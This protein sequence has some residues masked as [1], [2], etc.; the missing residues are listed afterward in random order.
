M[1][2]S[3][4]LPADAG[5]SAAPADD[6]TYL[7]RIDPLGGRW[8][9]ERIGEKDF[10][11]LDAQIDFSAGGFLNH[12]AGCGGGHPAFYRLNGGQITITRIERV[13]IGKCPG[14]TAAERT[15]AG[16]SEQVLAS[17]IDRLATW[18]REGDVLTLTARD[19][20][21]AVLRKPVDPNPEL[22]G[23]WLIESIGGRPL[24]TERRPATLSIGA[25]S[26]GAHADCNRMGTQFAIPSP[27]RMLVKG[28][29]MSTQIGCA[30]EDRAEDALMAGAITGAT[31]YRLDGDR[32]IFTGG[33]GMVVRRPPPPDRRLTGEYEAC[34]NTMLGAYHEGPITLAVSGNEMRD[35]AEC[36]AKYAAN[37]PD[38]ELRLAGSP[39]CAAVAPPYAAGQPVGVGGAISVLSVTRPDGFGFNNEGQLVL[40]TNR[41]LL[42]MC[43]KGT[44]LPFGN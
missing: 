28:P 21:R 4:A 26:I 38:L 16:N 29:V 3:A 12:G 8:R 27:G 19:G 20:T 11:G 30:P 31:A 36:S 18:S 5:T 25:G 2:P 32:L 13:R 37:G 24:V 14:G 35:N 44:P 7:A 23:R 42:T 10:S 1:R 33:P 17:F 39:A 15:A 22:A 41:G 9:V 6:G 43:R 40:R 34:G